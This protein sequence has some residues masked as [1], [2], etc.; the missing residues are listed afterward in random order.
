MPVQL[1]KPSRH[2]IYV[3]VVRLV[4][5]RGR[6]GRFEC[7]F[8]TERHKSINRCVS[9]HHRLLI[10][11]WRVPVELFQCV[12]SLSPSGSYLFGPTNHSLLCH[13][14][15]RI[16]WQMRTFSQLI[17]LYY[18]K[19]STFKI[20]QRSRPGNP[21]ALPVTAYFRL[22]SFGQQTD[23]RICLLQPETLYS[24]YTSE[25]CTFPPVAFITNCRLSFV[26]EQHTSLSVVRF[27]WR[28]T[29]S[30]IS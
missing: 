2:C 30:G 17:R 24:K 21:R 3:P 5:A 28:L 29:G 9:Y 11:R 4:F 12:L 27:F 8:V 14:L 7:C 1:I 6:S 19:S 10:G 18:S 20:E 25:I 15:G 26:F 22:A 13:A 23:A 16:E